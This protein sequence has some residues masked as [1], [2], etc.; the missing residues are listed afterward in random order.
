MDHREPLHK[1]RK[2]R[3]TVAGRKKAAP[4]AQV[5]GSALPT[6]PVYETELPPAPPLPMRTKE[7][8]LTAACVLM[9]VAPTR[10]YADW[11][12][13]EAAEGEEE[14]TLRISEIHEGAPDRTVTEDIVEP[15]PG[16]A[17]IEAEPG[18]SYRAEVIAH[19][20]EGYRV[21]CA[22]GPAVTPPKGPEP[23]HAALPL[24]ERFYRVTP[25][26]SSR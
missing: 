7:E 17:T 16:H 15:G 2:R 10:L 18:T 24:P 25:E 9:A 22:S 11:V 20:D 6:V 3:K 8:A 5:V 23:L 12:A 19:L 13:P 4:E 14:R 26:G 1:A 21:L